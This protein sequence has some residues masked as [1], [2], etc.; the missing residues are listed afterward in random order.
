MIEGVD[1]RVARTSRRARPHRELASWSSAPVRR[2]GP[3]AP[4]DLARCEVHGSSHEAPH[5]DRSPV[6]HRRPRPIGRVRRPAGGAGRQGRAPNSSRCRASGR[7]RSGSRRRRT[8]HPGPPPTRGVWDRRSPALLHGATGSRRRRVARAAVP[9]CSHLRESPDTS[10]GV[11]RARTRRSTRRR[12]TTGRA[13]LSRP[14][15]WLQL[16]PGARWPFCPRPPGTLNV[17]LRR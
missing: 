11:A 8:Q 6:G 13:W 4:P 12:S 14:P 7:G 2:C 1:G 15:R 9:S 3:C 17:A 16:A 5:L 10:T